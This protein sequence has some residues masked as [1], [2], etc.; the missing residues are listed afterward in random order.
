MTN[1][2]NIFLSIIILTGISILH[3]TSF[4]ISGNISAD[5]TWTGVDTV[6]VVGNIYVDN[7]KTLTIDPGIYAE[8]QGHYK[9]QVYG[10]LLAVG[11]AS[12][13]ITFTAADQQT[14]WN[15]LVFNTISPSNDSTRIVYCI[16]KYGRGNDGGA[17]FIKNFDK[18]LVS[19]CLFSNNYAEDNGGVI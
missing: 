14:G 7:G 8:F 12:E 10:T 6:K 16:L 15:R 11:T 4:E 1:L 5:T 17:L 2:K 13:R 19:N 9:I 18:I 3:S